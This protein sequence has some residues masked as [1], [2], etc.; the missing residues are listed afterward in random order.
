MRPRNL[1]NYRHGFLAALIVNGDK[2]DFHF[3]R[4]STMKINEYRFRKLHQMENKNIVSSL[5]DFH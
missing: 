3:A 2:F 5:N 4:K 1:H